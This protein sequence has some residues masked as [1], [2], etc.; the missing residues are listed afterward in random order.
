MPIVILDN[1][2]FSRQMPN[3]KTFFSPCFKAVSASS[4]LYSITRKSMCTVHSV[5]TVITLY[6]WQ[7]HIIMMSHHR[8][9]S[10]HHHNHTKYVELFN[11][12]T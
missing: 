9:I 8:I 3:M 2:Q 6:C 7:L 4:K 5:Q 12:A 10:Q 11:Q 1:G